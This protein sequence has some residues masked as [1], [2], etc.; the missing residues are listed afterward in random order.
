M[1]GAAVASHPDVLTK[2]EGPEVELKAFGERG[3]EFGV[4]FW[5]KGLDDGE[6]AYSSDVLFLIWNALKDNHIEIPYPRREIKI[7][8][9]KDAD[10]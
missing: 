8:E 5:C 3:I 10:E 7:L 6:N 4:E 2:P 9:D 1:V